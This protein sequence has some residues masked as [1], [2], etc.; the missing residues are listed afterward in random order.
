VGSA[1]C[2]LPID[3]LIR[4]SGRARRL[5]PADTI[6]KLLWPPSDRNELSKFAGYSADTVCNAQCAEGAPVEFMGSSGFS[7]GG[8]RLEGAL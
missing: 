3:F 1:E 7:A 2:P 8:I 6:P 4:R 5:R